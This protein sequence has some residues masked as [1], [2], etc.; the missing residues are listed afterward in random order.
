MYLLQF[1]VN[2]VKNFWVYKAYNYKESLLL[3]NHG[4]TKEFHHTYSNW[5]RTKPE[6]AHHDHAIGQNRVRVEEE[7]KGGREYPKRKRKS[8]ISWHA[9]VNVPA[10]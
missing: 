4:E 1:L 2:C 7:Q 5:N 3:T 9:P 8:I 6:R 10:N